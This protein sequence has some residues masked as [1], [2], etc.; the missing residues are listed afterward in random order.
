VRKFFKNSSETQHT[1]T[2][3]RDGGERSRECNNTREIL[4]HTRTRARNN[5][6]REKEKKKNEKRKRTE[7]KEDDGERTALS[8]IFLLS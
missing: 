2:H 1:L 6:E 5:N 7:E 3:A 8:E 4:V